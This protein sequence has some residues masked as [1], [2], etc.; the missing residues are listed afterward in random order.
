[1]PFMHFSR[2]GLRMAYAEALGGISGATL[3]ASYRFWQGKGKSKTRVK[4][5]WTPLPLE[6][7]VKEDICGPV[8]LLLK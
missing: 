8:L 4:E 2:W 1:M 7:Q 6:G 5:A 3:L